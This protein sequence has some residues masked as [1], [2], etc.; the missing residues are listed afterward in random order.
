MNAPLTDTLTRTV[1]ERPA[2]DFSTASLLHDAYRMR[3]R[4]DPGAAEVHFPASVYRETTAGTLYGPQAMLVAPPPGAG[5]ERPLTDNALF[6]GFVLVVAVAYVLLIYH[7]V[8]DLRALLNHVFSDSAADKRSFQEPTGSRYARFLYTAA[9]IG[10]LFIGMLVVKYSPPAAAEALFGRLSFAAV[11]AMSLAVSAV[12]ACVWGCQW[13]LLKGIGFFTSTQPL[14]AQLR[15]LRTRYFASA[16]LIAAPALLL[17]ALCPQHTGTT[18]FV[19]ALTGLA[20]TIFLYLRETVTLFLAKKVSIVHWFLYL[21]T[22][23]IF[24]IILL[25]QF[26]RRGL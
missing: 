9:G 4:P 1:G 6:Q 14:L 11:F 16:V 20:I 19:L 17:F 25:C 24:P 10:L 3:Y 26:A 8:T 22:I 13:L 2:R 21:C 12:G 15:Q 18:W 23:E 7:N 5:E